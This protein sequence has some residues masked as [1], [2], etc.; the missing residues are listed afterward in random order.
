M[1]KGGGDDGVKTSLGGDGPH[2]VDILGEDRWVAFWF[3]FSTAS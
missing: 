1:F 2:P 3:C